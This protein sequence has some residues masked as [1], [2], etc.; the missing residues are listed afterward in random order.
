MERFWDVLKDFFHLDQ[1]IADVDQVVSV[2]VYH[3]QF[4]ILICNFYAIF[5][6][7]NSSVI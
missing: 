7:A 5:Y 2:K 6:L 3:G 1:G 4:Y